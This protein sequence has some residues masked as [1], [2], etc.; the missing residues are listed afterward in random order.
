MGR[1]D[2]RTLSAKKEKFTGAYALE[3]FHSKIKETQGNWVTELKCIR[4]L[5]KSLTFLHMNPQKRNVRKILNFERKHSMIVEILE[6]NR[7]GF[8]FWI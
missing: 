3:V 2:H 6:P 1:K 8:K 7:P 4:I 5:I